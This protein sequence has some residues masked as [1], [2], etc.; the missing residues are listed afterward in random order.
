MFVNGVDNFPG[1][2]AKFF[3][4]LG[5]C[6]LH[7]ALGVEFGPGVVCSLAADHG[8]CRN[9]STNHELQVGLLT[10]ETAR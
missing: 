5:S 9:A 10:G 2:G 1:S 3:A 7:L 4:L 6:P 8:V